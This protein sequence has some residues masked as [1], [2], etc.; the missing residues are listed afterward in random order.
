MM[1]RLA[2]VSAVALFG[3]AGCDRAN[4]PAR[5]SAK[6]ET[7]APVVPAEPAAAGNAAPVDAPAPAAAAGTTPAFAPLYPGARI[8]GAPLTANGAAGPGGLV[9]FTTDASP[10]EVVAF[11]RQRAEAAGLKSVTGMNQGEARAYGAAGD[12]ADGPSLQ[13][14]AAPSPDGGTSV[15]M[16]WSAGS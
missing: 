12:T 3:L 4:A 11:Y 15:H 2:A 14:V 6:A 7:A 16:N 8:D 9:T 1:L 13:V 10:D 5:P